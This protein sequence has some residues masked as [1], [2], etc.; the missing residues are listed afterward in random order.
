M[1]FSATVCQVRD[2]TKTVTRRH[3][4]TWANLVPGDLLTAVEKS[5]GLPRG[6]TQEVLW[7]IRV[8]DVRVERL[9]DALQEQGGAAREGFPH[10]T[11]AGFVAKYRELMSG[12]LEQLVRRIEFGYVDEAIP[13]R[14]PGWWTCPSCA[15]PRRASLWPGGAFGLDPHG[16]ERWTP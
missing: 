9:S 6:A 2:R 13:T 4:E 10:L 16:C 15:L 3:H 5:M 7:V 11:E 12:G 1:S 14:D 8:I